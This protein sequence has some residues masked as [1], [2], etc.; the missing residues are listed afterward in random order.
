[1]R[2]LDKV[3]LRIRSLWQRNTVEREMSA[4]LQFHLEELTREN[5][6]AGMATREARQAALRAIGGVAQYEEECRDARGVNLIET[7]GS[8]VRYALRTL[9]KTPVFA[10][11]AVLSL[12]LGTGAN[13][14]I[15]SLI[16]S[17]LL[18]QLPVRNPEQLVLVR[19]SFIK[20]GAFQV[21]R[22]LSNATVAHLSRATQ[23]EGLA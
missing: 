20:V 11:V 18:Q 12:A 21:S 6:A 4:E 17:V 22:T 1:M 9:R 14:A 2:A 15:F 23:I 16:D 7:L 5:I 13:T 19:T 3:R 10:A 8:D